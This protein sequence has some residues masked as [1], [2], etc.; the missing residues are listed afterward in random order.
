VQ[1]LVV[2]QRDAER[3]A[4]AAL[5]RNIPRGRSLDAAT[6][7]Y[8]RGPLETLSESG[9]ASFN[10]F[11]DGLITGDIDVSGLQTFL[12]GRSIDDARLYLSSTLELAPDT[13]PE[14]VINPRFSD[15]LPNLPVRITV[16]VRD[17]PP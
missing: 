11:A 10:M 8:E 7:H 13:A 1:A 6:L 5:S 15:N 3:V 16:I 9:D 4:F 17:A 2:N 12:A 14:I